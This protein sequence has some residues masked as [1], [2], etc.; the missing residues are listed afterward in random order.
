MDIHLAGDRVA[1]VHIAC[2]ASAGA[3]G[4]PAYRTP[5]GC[6]LD[7]QQILQGQSSDCEPASRASSISRIIVSLSRSAQLPAVAANIAHALGIGL[8]RD[9]LITTEAEALAVALE[10]NRLPGASSR[11][12][13]SAVSVV[14]GTSGLHP[15]CRCAGKRLTVIVFILPDCERDAAGGG[16]AR[17]ARP[18]LSEGGGNTRR[19]RSN[20][21]SRS[22]P[23]CPTVVRR[24]CCQRV[25]P[26][27]TE[28]SA[29]HQGIAADGKHSSV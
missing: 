26:D 1:A 22:G 11:S 19:W 4:L 6:S 20:G 28:C 8:V 18:V 7:V 13:G 16:V 23:R 17:A 29:V 21:R 15:L 5:P 2:G 25:V 24:Q 9:A 12:S 14:T 3:Y 10:N 27:R